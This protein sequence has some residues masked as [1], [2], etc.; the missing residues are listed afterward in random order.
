MT[1]DEKSF[2]KAVL[3]AAR[4]LGWLAAHHHDSRRQ[5]RPGVFV[6]DKDATGFPDIFLVH[7]KKKQALAL[8]LKV[9]KGRTRPEQVEWIDALDKAGIPSFIVR[10]QDWALI[11]RLLGAK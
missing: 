3:E 8:E 9:H 1:Q 6:G 7:P 2:T 5:V 10:P 4:A 11:R